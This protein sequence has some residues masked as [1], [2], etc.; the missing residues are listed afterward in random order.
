MYFM[1][2]IY[3]IE[4]FVADLYFDHYCRHYALWGT[5][6][7]FNLIDLLL[8]W[9]V[10]ACPIGWDHQHIVAA[11][12]RIVP[13]L[14]W[15]PSWRQY[16]YLRTIAP[17]FIRRPLTG[18]GTYIILVPVWGW[19]RL[20]LQWLLLLRVLPLTTKTIIRKILTYECLKQNKKIIK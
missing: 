13:M 17:T 12:V 11:V 18:Y 20:Y 3:Y 5:P 6:Y 10:N 7:V 15:W 19:Y 4:T 8:C 1:R 14:S 2:L 16:Y 9:M